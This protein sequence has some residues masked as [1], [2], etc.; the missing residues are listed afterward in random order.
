MSSLLVI[1]YCLRYYSKVKYFNTQYTV[2]KTIALFIAK[3][4]SIPY[5]HMVIH[6]SQGMIS[7]HRARLSPAQDWIQ[8]QNK[9]K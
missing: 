6:T 7:E 9:R 8:P 4:G 3:P 5:T 1:Y 2:G